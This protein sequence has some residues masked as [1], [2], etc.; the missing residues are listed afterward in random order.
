[1]PQIRDWFPDG[2]DFVFMHDGAPCHMAKSVKAFLESKNIPVL[3]WPGNSPDMNPIENVWAILK[4]RM[5]KQRITNKE[6]LI[7]RL[8][9]VWKEPELIAAV[10]SC[11]RSM[12][13]RIKTLLR[14]KG[15]RT[16]Y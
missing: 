10:K 11:I 1:L 7:R 6:I 9:E 12:P 3:S 14:Q 15:R 16:K 8:L 13:K 4:R 2:Q 5:A